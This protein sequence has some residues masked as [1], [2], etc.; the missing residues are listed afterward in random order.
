FHLP[1]VE[2]AGRRRVH[3]CAAERD[4]AA[5]LVDEV[6]PADVLQSRRRQFR[7]TRVV[8]DEALQVAGTFLDRFQ[9]Q[10][11]PVRIAPA[12][13]LGAGVGERGDRGQRVVELV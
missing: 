5:Q 3:G 8:A 10:V 12:Q 1:R 6:R 4:L 9:Y 11:E 2:A 13:Q 7:E